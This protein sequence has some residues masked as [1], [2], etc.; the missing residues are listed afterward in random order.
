[1]IDTEP[2]LAAGLAA[3]RGRDPLIDDLVRNG[4]EPP[5]R[6]RE[7]GFPGLVSIVVAQ[8]VS[9]ASAAAILRRLEEA[10]P[11]L[12]ATSMAATEDAVLLG[13]GLSRPKLRTLRA[14]GAAVL[15]GDLPLD[16]L[17]TE[18]PSRARA[19]LTSVIGIGPWTAD[20]YLLFCVGHPDIFPSG[21]LALREAARS[22]L[23]LAERPD[24]RGLGAIAERWSPWRGIAALVLWTHYRNLKGRRG[25]VPTAARS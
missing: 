9:T 11:G 24:A 2:A 20:I 25:D 16:R 19:L 6:K 17:G 22:A 21:D 8:Q 14:A 18:E 5:L 4:A 7:G 12:S 1:M 10:V 23:R 3:L 13:A 15:A